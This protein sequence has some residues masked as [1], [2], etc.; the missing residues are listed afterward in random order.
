VRFERDAQLQ[1]FLNNRKKRKG[2]RMQLSLVT[3]GLERAQVRWKEKGKNKSNQAASVGGGSA[4]NNS[5]QSINRG[6][7]F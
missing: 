7:P 5:N 4:I 3:R 1:L 6:D 2:K